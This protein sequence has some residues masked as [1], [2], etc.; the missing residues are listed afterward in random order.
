MT[1]NRNTKSPSDFRYIDFSSLGLQEL[2]K[3]LKI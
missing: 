1:G 2:E 3:K